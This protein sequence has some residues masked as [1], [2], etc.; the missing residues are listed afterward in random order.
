MWGR[1][2]RGRGLVSLG[3]RGVLFRCIQILD[4][5]VIV[6]RFCRGFWRGRG[7]I[8]SFALIPPLGLTLLRSQLPLGGEEAERIVAEMFAGGRLGEFKFVF[9]FLFDRS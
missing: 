4:P 1:A 9:W 5:V 8:H 2:V 7:L 6:F 3:W